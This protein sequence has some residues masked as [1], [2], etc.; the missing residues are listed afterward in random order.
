MVK[1]IRVDDRLLHGQII[2]AWVPFIKADSL[3]VSSDEAARDAIASEIIESCGRNCFS[4]YVKSVEETAEFVTEE[5]DSERVILVVGG[6]KDAMKIYEAGMR[7]A[8]INIGNVHHEGRQVTPSV[9]FDSEDEEIIGR[10]EE[11]GVEIDIR[12]VPA[13]APT[14]YEHRKK[15]YV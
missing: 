9:I 1:L 3:V 4:V 13:S 10:F 2:C 15:P 7:F 6:L 12:D 14:T 8:S 11:L 5:C